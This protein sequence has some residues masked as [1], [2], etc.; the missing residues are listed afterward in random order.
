MHI[1]IYSCRGKASVVLKRKREEPPAPAAAPAAASGSGAGG[2][3]GWSALVE[4]ARMVAEGGAA[5]RALYGIQFPYGPPRRRM[6]FPYP[7]AQVEAD[8]R[9]KYKD[10]PEYRCGRAWAA[11]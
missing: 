7:H 1:L 8:L 2:D 10:D 9:A 11:D 4:V 3:A 6:H 5:V